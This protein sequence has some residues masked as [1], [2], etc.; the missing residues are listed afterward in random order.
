MNTKKNMNT[1]TIQITMFRSTLCPNLRTVDLVSTNEKIFT[2][3]E[4]TSCKEIPWSSINGFPLIPDW[5]P[6][7]EDTVN[8][9]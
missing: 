6:L 9:F 4:E 3:K 5:C 1:R 8:C 2:C 7:S